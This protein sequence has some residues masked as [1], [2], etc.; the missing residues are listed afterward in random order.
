MIREL[1]D[2]VNS[3]V[4]LIEADGA[5]RLPLKAPYDHEP[6]IPPDASLVV[7]VVGSMCGGSRWTNSTCITR[8]AFRPAMAILKARRFCPR[9][10]P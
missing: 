8:P 3:D 1:V 10:W 2:A 7:P 5:C 9:G 6:V 4:L